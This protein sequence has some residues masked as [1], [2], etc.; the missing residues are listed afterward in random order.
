MNSR[1]HIVKQQ[2]IEAAGLLQRFIDDPRQWEAFEQAGE[3][4]VQAVRQGHRIYA[5][6]NG[7][8]M[9]DAMHFAEEM[10][11]RFRKNRKPYPAMAIGDAAHLTC[12]AND[13]GYDQIFAR[14][15]EAF[16]AAGD[17]LLAIS[18]SGNS[19]NILKAVEAGRRKGMHVIALTGKTGGELAGCCDVELRAPKSAWSDRAQEIHIKIIHALI[20]YTELSIDPE[21]YDA[22]GN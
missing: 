5:C 4:M 1:L 20:L 11:G 3:L 22:T 19:A 7:G 21:L 6:G 9:C 14:H 18:T 16:G 2:F 12:T 15:V 17:I 8:S 13:Y 10:T